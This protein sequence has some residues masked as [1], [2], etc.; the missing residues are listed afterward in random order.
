MA[1]TLV[2]SGTMTHRIDQIAAAG[3][4][5]PQPACTTGAS[6]GCG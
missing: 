5:S 2:G 4:V 3:W 6:S 1:E